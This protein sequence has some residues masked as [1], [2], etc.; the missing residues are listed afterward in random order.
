MKIS[1]LITIAAISVF[2]A[3]FSGCTERPNMSTSSL[4]GIWYCSQSHYNVDNLNFNNDGT[5]YI[6]TFDADSSYPQLLSLKFTYTYDDNIVL[7]SPCWNDWLM[8][9]ESDLSIPTWLTSVGINGII[10]EGRV[11]AVQKLS[12]AEIE[13]IEF[14]IEQ[15]YD[16]NL[17]WAAEE[18]NKNYDLYRQGVIDKGEYDARIQNINEEEDVRREMLDKRKAEFELMLKSN[19]KMTLSTQEEMPINI[20]TYFK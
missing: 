1:K 16:A 8:D 5:C 11:E 17:M 20:G 9:Y 18:R 7:L 10:I 15:D 2:V 12:E 13:E 14:E 19:L 6:K 3:V 4:L